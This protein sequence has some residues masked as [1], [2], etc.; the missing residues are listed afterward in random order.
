MTFHNESD[1]TANMSP[2][3]YRAILSPVVKIF[4]G[5]DTIG[6]QCGRGNIRVQ[7]RSVQ[8]PANCGISIGPSFTGGNRKTARYEYEKR[9]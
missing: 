6:G 8:I 9:E 2:P 5:S 1:Y 4:T 3:N 7:E